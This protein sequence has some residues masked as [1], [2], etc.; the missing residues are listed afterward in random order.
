MMAG[1]KLHHM[2]SP[3]VRKNGRLRSQVA[4][5]VSVCS[6]SYRGVA[7]SMIARLKQ[8]RNDFSAA[9]QLFKC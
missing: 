9:P 8:P 1:A 6:W 4:L 5:A 2:R 3:Y 7:T